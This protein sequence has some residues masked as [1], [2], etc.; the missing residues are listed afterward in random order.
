MLAAEAAGS[1]VL[2]F[3]DFVPWK[4]PY[5]ALGGA[6][7]PTEFALFP[8]TDGSWRI[9]AIPPE[10][11]SFAQKRPL[12]AAWGGLT[13]DALVAA[14]G[15]PGAKFCHKNLFIAVFETREGALAALERARLV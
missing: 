9:V 3:D 14:C 7:H 11:G 4:E 6:K 13:D 5:F 1:N 2:A 10:H 8:G 15:V 12:P